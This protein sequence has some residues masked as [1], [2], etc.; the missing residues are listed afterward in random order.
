V[1]GDL[2]LYMTCGP[3]NNAYLGQRS[4][5]Y[6][7]TGEFNTLEYTLTPEQVN[8]LNGSYASCTVTVALNVNSGSGAFRLDNMGFY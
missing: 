5:T 6:L 1:Y 2:Q 3:L 7:F 4:L 8:V